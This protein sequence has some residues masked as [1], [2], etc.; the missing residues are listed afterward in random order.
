[1]RSTSLIALLVASCLLCIPITVVAYCQAPLQCH[2]G[3]SCTLSDAYCQ[4]LPIADNSLISNQSYNGWYYGYKNDNSS[5]LFNLYPYFDSNFQRWRLNVTGRPYWGASHGVPTSSI[6]SVMRYIPPPSLDLSAP[7]S[8]QIQGYFFRDSLYCSVQANIIKDGQVLWSAIDSQGY[9]RYF[10]L[11][12]SVNSSSII[13]F[14]VW[15]SRFND[16]CGG[17]FSVTILSPCKSDCSNILCLRPNTT[18][19]CQTDWSGELCRNYTAP[20]YYGGG[21]GGGGS[22]PL[23][24]TVGGIVGT[25]VFLSILYYAY[26]RCCKSTTI[27]TTGTTSDGRTVRVDLVVI[28]D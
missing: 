12:V 18:C 8:L 24:G 13:D 19:T 20:Y 10:S 6:G 17:Y 5:S 26:V 2:I 28:K 23:S 1:M 22:S 21:G 15:A 7:H 16:G 4:L 3:N 27:S 9:Y 25:L 11:S 14:E